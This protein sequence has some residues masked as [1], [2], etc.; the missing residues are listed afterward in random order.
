MGNSKTHWWIAGAVAVALVVYLFITQRPQTPAN[1]PV[2]KTVTGE[3]ITIGAI[4]PLTG[5]AAAYGTPLQRAIEI[6]LDEINTANGVGGRP[7]RVDFQDGK[8]SGTDGANAAQNLISV[9]G[10]KYIIG[11]ACSGETLGF[12]PIANE[13]K[14][15][16]ISPSATSPDITTNGGEYVF[17]LSPSDALAGKVAAQY[18]AKDLGARRAALISE[19][20]DYAQGLRKTFADAFKAQGGSVVVDE[21]YQTGDTN[22]RSQALKV[23]TANVDVVYLLPQTPTPGVLVVKQLKENGITAALFTAEVMIGR[24]VVAGNAADLEGLVGFEAFFDEKSERAKPFLNAYQAKYNEAPP[25]PFFMANAHA[26]TYLI[27]DLIE[28]NQMDTEK[29]RAS[30]STLTGWSGGALSSVSLDPAGDP[31]WKDYSVKQVLQ[32]ELNDVKVFSA[33]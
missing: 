23:K 22:F 3:A 24:D 7:L 26:I 14:V 5:D 25:F 1:A 12:A 21:T 30:L 11:G 9:K 28:Q 19:Q 15:I 29:A 31:I 6:A 13:N 4:L 32:G 27:K 2:P 16:V 10:I 17:R 18:A 20:T 33:E 8:C